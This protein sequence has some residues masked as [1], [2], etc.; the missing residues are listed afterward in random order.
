MGVDPQDVL[1]V[2]DSVE[3]DV[4]GARAAGMSAVLL[5]RASRYESQQP[6]VRSLVQLLEL[7]NPE[8]LETSAGAD[9]GQACQL[10][11]K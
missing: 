3:H 5:D 7:L 8:A 4:M 2:G 10:S 1:Y 9:C 11:D 6:K